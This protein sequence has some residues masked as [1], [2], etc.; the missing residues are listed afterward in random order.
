MCLIVK[1]GKVLLVRR[2]KDEKKYPDRWTLPSGHMEKGENIN[3][4]LMREMEEELGVNPMSYEL[5]LTVPHIDEEGER[6]WYL[7]HVKNWIGTITNKS[8]N[9]ELGWFTFEEAERKDMPRANE[10]MRK[11]GEIMEHN[12]IEEWGV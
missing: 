11:V 8:E 2:K 4:T 12:R 3:T 10:Y 9:A 7:F 5:V 1:D 6:F